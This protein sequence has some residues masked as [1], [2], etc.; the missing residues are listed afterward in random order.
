MVKYYHEPLDLIFF[1]LA[2]RTRR[3]MLMELRKGVRSAKEL[4]QPFSLSL[5]AI[6]KHL[7]ILEKANLI[8]RKIEGRQHFFDVQKESIKQAWEWGNYYLSFWDQNLDQL[9]DYLKDLEEPHE[10]KS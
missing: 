2:D 5:P 4:A 6:T 9:A 10:P 7:K 8:S 3:K 1:A